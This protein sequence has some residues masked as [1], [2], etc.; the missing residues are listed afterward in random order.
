M[1][2]GSRRRR[3]VAALAGA[4]ELPCLQAFDELRIAD[5]PRRI[6]VESG[7]QRAGRRLGQ[8]PQVRLPVEDTAH[9]GRGRTGAEGGPP[10]RGEGDDGRKRPPVR[11]GVGVPA[12]QDDGIAVAGGVGERPGHGQARVLAE[13]GDA[14]IDED[15]PL[16]ADH[17][18]RRLE[19]AVEDPD[20]VD[21]F[22]GL[23]QAPGEVGEVAAVVDPRVGDVLFEGRAVDELGDDESLRLVGLGVDDFRDE[24]AADLLKHGDLAPQPAAARLLGQEP[25]V[26]ELQGDA[27]AR[28]VLRLE[29]GGHASGADP[30]DQ[31]VSPDGRLLAHGSKLPARRRQ[32]YRRSRA[33]IPA[34]RPA[35]PCRPPGAARGRC[36][37]PPARIP[38]YARDDAKSMQ[39][40]SP[41]LAS[42]ENP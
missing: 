37:E 14:E 26:E 41:P 40:F 25:G 8:A 3:R 23:P 42:A 22:D 24:G 34:P 19:V 18:V 35:A 39:Y 2:A 10:R 31:P 7:L 15:G 28:A 21:R 6:G 1:P 13:L 29:D 30:L 4:G 38:T 9:D 16:R 27:V 33:P 12:V 17:D 20:A 36:R 32:D 11:L 5:P